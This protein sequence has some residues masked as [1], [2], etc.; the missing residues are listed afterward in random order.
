MPRLILARVGLP[1]VSLRAVCVGPLMGAS[2]GVHVFGVCSRAHGAGCWCIPRVCACLQGRHPGPCW[3]GCRHGTWNCGSTCPRTCATPGNCLDGLRM[4]V[5]VGH[6]GPC[7]R[8]ACRRGGRHLCCGIGADGRY[9]CCGTG[10]DGRAELWVRVPAGGRESRAG[11]EVCA[12]MSTRVR[13]GAS[14]W[15]LH[16][17]LMSWCGPGGQILGLHAGGSAGALC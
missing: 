7:G 15:C 10:V 5:S 9:L 12:C 17:T 14:A 4:C 13:C 6:A 3:P 16:L 8:L 2:V 1:R 11:L